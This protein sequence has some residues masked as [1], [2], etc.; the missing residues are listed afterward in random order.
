VHDVALSWQQ[1]AV[2]TAALALVAAT[3]T[4]ARGER[5]RQLAPFV[6]EATMIGGL[7][8]LWQLAGTLSVVGTGGAI[9]RAEWIERTERTWHLPSEASVQS[10]LTGN[11]FL[12]QA[13]N[14][15]YAT[16]HFGML[17]VFLIWLFVRHRERYRPIRRVLALTTLVCLL[18]QL[19]PVAPP[20]MLPGYVDIAAKYNQSVYDNLGFD[21]DQ[22]SA[23][24]SVHVAWAVLIAWATWRIGRGPWRFLGC[25]HAVVTILVVVATA[26]HFWADGIVAV[27][28]LAICAAIENTAT[29]A[30]V[31][32]SSRLRVG[33]DPPVE[34]SASANGAILR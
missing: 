5:L 10:A 2:V 11:S 23:M 6:R 20:R 32:L 29:R 21:A 26:N 1:S 22:L 33:D 4:L 16:M 8:S 14:L 19:V 7:Y 30:V 12:A 34:L 3:L 24:P 25:G 27:A 15:Y 28:V 13:E 18:I 17:F 31:H 9:S